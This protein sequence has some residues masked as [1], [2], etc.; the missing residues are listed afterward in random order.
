MTRGGVGG[1]FR[2]LV[3]IQIRREQVLPKYGTQSVQ[4]L[5][6]ALRRSQILAFCATRSQS[7]L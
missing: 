3:I 6:Y 2:I 4:V 1:S 5:N 7:V